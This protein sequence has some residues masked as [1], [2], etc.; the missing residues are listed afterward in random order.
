LPAPGRR[1]G[2]S[3]ELG[4]FDDPF[5]G[6]GAF[7]SERHDGAPPGDGCIGKRA[8]VLQDVVSKSE[9]FE[10]HCTAVTDLADVFGQFEGFLCGLFALAFT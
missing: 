2:R 3:P 9:V 6:G 4:D 8:S 10:V 5:F 7:G 1:F